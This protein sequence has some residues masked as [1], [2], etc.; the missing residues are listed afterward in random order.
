M[1]LDHFSFIAYDTSVHDTLI[2][3]AITDQVY[4]WEPYDLVYEY[5]LDWLEYRRIE[6]PGY[7][8]I[9]YI[10][11]KSVRN[12][13]KRIDDILIKH[14]TQE[15][16]TILSQLLKTKSTS[17]DEYVLTTLQKP[18]SISCYQAVMSNAM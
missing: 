18:P 9:Q 8:R 2:L 11:T 10:I 14:L 16:K 13:D 12:R 15:Q 17:S 7:Y 6:K 3:G 5:I 1:I 4:S